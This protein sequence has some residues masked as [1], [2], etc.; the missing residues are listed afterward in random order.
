MPESNLFDLHKQQAQRQAEAL[1]ATALNGAEAFACSKG[2]RIPRDPERARLLDG[3]EFTVPENESS[4]QWLALPFSKGGDPITRLVAH[5]KRGDA[6]VPIE[7]FIGTL[8]KSATKTDGTVARSTV[9]FKDST[10]LADKALAC[11][12]PTDVWRL[13]FGKTF[14][15]SNATEHNVRSIRNGQPSSRH[16]YTYTFTEV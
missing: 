6:I 8:L 1:G 14:K 10:N 12:D 11:I 9:L 13:C 7:V 16:T 2:K 15:V 3:D 4:D 5:V